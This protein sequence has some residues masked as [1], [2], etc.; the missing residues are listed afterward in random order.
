MEDW[1]N[2]KKNISG[3]KTIQGDRDLKRKQDGNK[4]AIKARLLAKQRA[5]ALA[6]KRAE[7]IR[8]VAEA[9]K[10]MAEKEEESKKILLPDGKWKAPVGGRKT[11]RR[12]KKKKS[13]KTRRKTRKKRRRKSRKKRKTRRR[14]KGGV[15]QSAFKK[16]LS[17]SKTVTGNLAGLALQ[18]KPHARRITRTGFKAPKP[19]SLRKQFRPISPQ[20][21]PQL[22]QQPL[23]GLAAAQQPLAPLAQQ[24][25]A[26]QMEA[27]SI[28]TPSPVSSGGEEI[29]GFMNP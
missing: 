9:R 1:K 27:M 21:Q 13:R 20:S 26:Q 28:N 29:T 4:E 7:V 14:K 12:R 16:T 8:K 5:N 23:Q 18:S 3:K 11:R 17:R 19:S 6:K 10:K 24:P 2:Y 25:L 22:M 15:K